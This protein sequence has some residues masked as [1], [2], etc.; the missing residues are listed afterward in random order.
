MLN[1]DC[2]YLTTVA[3]PDS[4]PVPPPQSVV[5]GFDAFEC[6]G[7][8]LQAPLPLPPH[9]HLLRQRGAAAGRPRPRQ[10]HPLPG[11]WGRPQGSSHRLCRPIAE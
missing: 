4:P 1:R 3:S 5:W 2:E 7:L 9:F 11:C 10:T 6:A 8:A